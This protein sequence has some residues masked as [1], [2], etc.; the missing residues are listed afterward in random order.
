M[1]I[2]NRILLLERDSTQKSKPKG[3]KKTRRLFI[4]IAE[5]SRSTAGSRAQKYNHGVLSSPSLSSACFF[6]GFILWHGLAFCWQDNH[7]PHTHSHCSRFRF[8]VSGLNPSSTFIGQ[9]TVSIPSLIHV[10]WRNVCFSFKSVWL[11]SGGWIIR[12]QEW[13]G[14]TKEL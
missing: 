12:S 8:Q 6:V 10:S 2:F 11:L 3:T 1:S 14:E 9:I 5:K 4:C 7:L 13:N